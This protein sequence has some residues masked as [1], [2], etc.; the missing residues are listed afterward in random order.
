MVDISVPEAVFRLIRERREHCVEFMTNGNI[1][2]IEQYREIMG[3][4]EALS[5]VEQELKSLLNKQERSDD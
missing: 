1:K 3:N 4:L 5:F 2:S